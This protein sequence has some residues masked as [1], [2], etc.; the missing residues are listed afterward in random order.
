ML[1][2][3]AGISSGLRRNA[4][5]H[6]SLTIFQSLR[7]NA[8]RPRS[9]PSPSFPANRSIVPSL[10][11]LRSPSGLHSRQHLLLLQLLLFGYWGDTRD[12][13][14]RALKLLGQPVLTPSIRVLFPQ[15]PDL[16]DVFGRQVVLFRVRLAHWWRQILAGGSGAGI[17][18]GGGQ[19]AAYI[20][21]GEELG[22][23]M[24]H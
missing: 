12:E 5:C 2:P 17:G 24:V 13:K 1:L 4:C 21:F 7:T 3:S 15:S 20:I 8:S 18:A 14:A 10:S 9:S 6:R 16:V 19:L 22:G 23:C 11:P